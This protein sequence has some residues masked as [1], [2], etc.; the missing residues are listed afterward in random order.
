MQVLTQQY[1]STLG[2]AGSALSLLPSPPPTAPAPSP[3]SPAS[4]SAGLSKKDTIV[5]AVLC[6]VGTAVVLTVVV[7]GVWLGRR[8]MRKKHVGLLGRILPP[9]PGLQTTL[10]VTDVQ[11]RAWRCWQCAC[12]LAAVCCAVAWHEQ[13]VLRAV[14]AQDST[15]L[16]E[17]LPVSVVDQ[18]M[19]LLCGTTRALLQKHNGYESCTEVRRR[20]LPVAAASNRALCRMVA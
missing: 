10:V 4:G 3:P 12:A 8:Y 19:Q 6:S 7:L 9:G 11:V 17:S 14:C 5:I 1:W 20:R 16:F 18:C 15:T 2:K 13:A